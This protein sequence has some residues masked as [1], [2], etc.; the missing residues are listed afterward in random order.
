MP[1]DRGLLAALELRKQYLKRVHSKVVLKKGD[2]DEPKNLRVFPS[3]E[4]VSRM[5]S[6]LSMREIQIM[7]SLLMKNLSPI[8]S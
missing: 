6:G 1:A 4:V 8:L 7:A 3:F 5:A 2:V